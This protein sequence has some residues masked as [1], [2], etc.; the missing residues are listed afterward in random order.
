MNYQAIESATKA[1]TEFCLEKSRA[2]YREEIARQEKE[3]SFYVSDE[4]CTIRNKKTNEEEYPPSMPNGMGARI[5]IDDQSGEVTTYNYGYLLPKKLQEEY[6][7]AKEW[8]PANENIR[9]NE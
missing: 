7:L 4:Y 1:I 3:C 6:K 2:N 8:L 5:V 9:I